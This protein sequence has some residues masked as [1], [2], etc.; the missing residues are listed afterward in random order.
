MKKQLKNTLVYSALVMA[1]IGSQVQAAGATFIP[2]AG[3]TFK[4]A[5]YSTKLSSTASADVSEG[6]YVTLNLSLTAAFDTFYATLLL[7]QGLTEGDFSE[8]GGGDITNDG[9]TFTVGC[10]CIDSVKDLSLFA[11]VNTIEATINSGLDDGDSATNLKEVAEDSGLF[12]GASY[13]LV[14]NQNGRLTATLAYAA[15]DGETK[16]TSDSFVGTLGTDTIIIKGDTT[17]LSYGIA[18]AGQ[19]SETLDYSVSYKIQDYSTD[20]DTISFGTTTGSLSDVEL[21][22]K[23]GMLSAQ[24]TSYF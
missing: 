8:Q 23:F 5:E 18:W 6:D 17:G 15:L 11:G 4:N 20:A 3:L 1:G 12:F 21:D 24:V 14:S 22:R 19:L 9:V 13:P 2:S 7:E 10:N 16:V